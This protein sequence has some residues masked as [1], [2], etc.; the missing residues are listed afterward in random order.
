MSNVTI[1]F[2]IVIS[3]FFLKFYYRYHCSI[4]TYSYCY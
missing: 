1:P 3:I 2:K 4:W